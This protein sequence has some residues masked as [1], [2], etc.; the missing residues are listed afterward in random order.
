MSFPQSRREIITELFVNGAWTDI[1]GDVRQN[2]GITITRGRRNE[3]SRP[4]PSTCNLTLNNHAGDY[5]PLNPAGTY[6]PSFGRNTP[7]RVGIWADVEDTFTRTVSNGWGTSTSGHAWTSI[8]AGGTVNS[9]DWNVGSGVGTHSVPTTAAYRYSYLGT[10]S[11]RD[12]DITIDCSLSFTDVTGGGIEPANL[13]LRWQSS[14]DYYLVRVAIDTSENITIDLKR[15]ITGG[16]E[17]LLSAAV[18]TGY[19][20][21]SSQT[22]RVRGQIEGSTIRAKVWPA[23][24]SEPA[25]WQ[26][27][28]VDDN[29]T[30]T[31]SVGVRSGVATGNSN[32]KPIVF[33]YDNLKVRHPRFT[34]EISSVKPGWDTSGNDVYAEIEAAG[35]GRR[36]GKGSPPL[37]SSLRRGILSGAITT[38]VQYW[39]CEE[40]EAATHFGSLISGADVMK[41]VEGTPSFGACDDFDSSDP[42]PFPKDSYWKGNVP[43]HTVVDIA[44]VQFLLSVPDAGITGQTLVAIGTS[45]SIATWLVIVDASGNM[46]LK[47]FN[48]AG[49]EVH[50]S[51]LVAYDVNGNPLRVSV[52]YWQNGANVECNL[53]TVAPGAST[54]SQLPGGGDTIASQTVGITKFVQVG[55]IGDVGIGHISVHREWSSIFA[56]GDQLNAWQGE[57][58][59]DRIERLCAEEGIPFSSVGDS[60]DTAVMGPQKSKTLLDLLEECADADLGSL[61]EPKGDI[62][63]A[64]RTRASLY[65]QNALLDLDYGAGEIAPPFVP[66]Y[67]DQL[68]RN[69]VTAKRVDGSEARAVLLSGRM[70]V[71]PPKDGGVGT[72]DD[73]VTVNVETDEPLPD[74][75]NWLVHLGTVDET[76]YPVIK[77]M[78]SNPNVVAAGI[79]EDVLMVSIDDR[80]T[81]SNPKS[82]QVPTASTVSQI[83]RGY[84]EKLNTFEHNLEFNCAP[85]SPYRVI[86]LDDTEF[87]L[88]SDATTLNEDLDTTETSVE[89]AIAT[90]NALWTT[91]AGEMPIAI[92]IGGEEMSVTAIS[93]A[94][95]PQ[96]F[97]VTRS[98]NG[99]V[100]THSTGDAVHVAHPAIIAL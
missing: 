23:S 95:S 6:Y 96:T 65:N 47:A 35:V 71:L 62:G 41:I 68:T 61:F 67:D 74:I 50:D 7:I 80:L 75:A 69:D 57:R 87:R 85:E 37:K 4:Q 91:D 2:D 28:A 78:L 38:P 94:S 29:L 14:V 9:S 92:L 13:I 97:T 98:V 73:S 32:T 66:T 8:G 10:T 45:G 40:G 20:H 33:S 100:K 52:E 59:G 90:G 12:I 77:V 79:E 55:S 1:T 19:N 11:F 60:A 93:G 30:G 27:S 31:G 43:A 17:A 56:L 44:Q 53:V 5:S 48:R 64:Y 34:G 99:V 89:V 36:L 18:D 81:I 46:R 83:V 72:Y 39:P 49:T 26:V 21:S 76:R 16:T 88:D 54:G 15:N 86:E 24:G 22:L 51:G 3:A 84:A 82:G 25:D 63:I 42:L 58:A 70:S